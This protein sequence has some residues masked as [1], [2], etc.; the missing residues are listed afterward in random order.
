LKTYFDT[1]YQPISSLRTGLSNWK[2]YHTNW[3]WVE[4]EITIGAA[5]TVLTSNGASSAP[6]FQSIPTNFTRVMKTADESATTDTTLSDDSQLTFAMLANTK[7]SFRAVMHIYQWSA[8]DFKYR[9]NWPASPTLLS[10]HRRAVVP[11]W[12][13]FSSQAIDTSYSASDITVLGTSDNPSIV[14]MEWIIHN[15]ANAWNFTISWAQ[16]SSSGTATVV[17]AWSYIEYTAL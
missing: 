6:T 3:S 11:A 16:N 4:T 8:G 17:R 9:H 5:A 10:I 15:G 14:L 1:L 7:Y 13:A 12:T 2:M